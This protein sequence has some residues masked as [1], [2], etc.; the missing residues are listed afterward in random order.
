MAKRLYLFNGHLIG[1]LEFIMECRKIGVNPKGNETYY[2]A[3]QRLS[4][5]GNLLAQ[6][7]YL[8]IHDL[9]LI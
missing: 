6:S 2:E 8:S 5:R 7:L 3:L 4:R 9:G 1:N